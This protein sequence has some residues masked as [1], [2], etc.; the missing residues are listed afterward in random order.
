MLFNPF[1]VDAMVG[2][3]PQTGFHITAQGRAAHPGALTSVDGTLCAFD[4]HWL[5]RYD[6]QD[7]DPQDLVQ[8]VLLA[9]SKDL[10]SFDHPG[11]PG[12]FRG[13]LKAILT[14]RSFDP[15]RGC[16]SPSGLMPHA[17]NAFRFKAICI[18]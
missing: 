17:P 12:A 13:W 6:A 2:C 5:H 16:A 11:Q 7:S 10:G 3:D 15:G 18:K 9:V 4:S 14:N 1:G 8:E